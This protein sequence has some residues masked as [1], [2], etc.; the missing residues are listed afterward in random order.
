MIGEE[1]DDMDG[2][3]GGLAAYFRNW[4][5]VVVILYGVVVLPPAIYFL[6]AVLRYARIPEILCVAFGFYCLHTFIDATAEPSTTMTTIIEETAK[7]FCAAS[8]ALA[9][10]VGLI[11]TIEKNDRAGASGQPGKGAS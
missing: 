6:P 2:F 4:N 5:D 3:G 11:G 10:F 8:L 9:F 7:L 1:L